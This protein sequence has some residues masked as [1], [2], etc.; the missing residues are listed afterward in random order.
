MKK[1][2]FVKI[3]LKLMLLFVHY[4]MFFQ[5][6]QIV[7]EKKRKMVYNEGVYLNI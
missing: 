4:I 1:L 2:S 3:K 6:L 5:F 7:L